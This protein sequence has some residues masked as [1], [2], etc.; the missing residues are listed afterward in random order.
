MD[1]T[2]ILSRMEVIFSGTGGVLLIAA[3]GVSGIIGAHVLRM[4]SSRRRHSPK[5]K[6][7]RDVVIAPYVDDEGRD[8]LEA[9][10]PKLSTQQ[11]QF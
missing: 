11:E 3:I 4:K 8:P 10:V 9:M 7:Y 6:S 2:A 1:Y 5:A